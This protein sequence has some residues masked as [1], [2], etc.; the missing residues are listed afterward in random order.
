MLIH[1]TL[2]IDDS[3][4]HGFVVLKDQN[5]K[6][7]FK[8]SNMIVGNGR[9]SIYN[10]ICNSVTAALSNNNSIVAGI[11]TSFNDNIFDHFSKLS[12]GSN[13]DMTRL[14]TSTIKEI[15]DD[16]EDSPTYTILLEESD[17]TPDTEIFIKFDAEIRCIEFEISVSAVLPAEITELGLYYKDTVG[18][19]NLFSRVVFDPI[20]C[21]PNAA[22]TELKLN[23]YVYF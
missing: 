15:S 11:N 3:I 18:N 16:D 14:D 7:I 1:D 23:Y 9:A 13:N 5:N 17:K 4:A 10:K 22:V 2:K 20:F 8:K 21:G 19:E 6:T 12:F